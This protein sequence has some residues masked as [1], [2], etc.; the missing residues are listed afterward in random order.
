MNRT[1]TRTLGVLLGSML[2]L[3]LNARATM[4]ADDNFTLSVGTNLSTITDAESAGVGTYLVIQGTPTNNLTVT[5]ITALGFGNGNVLKW[6]GGGQT[7]YRPFNGGSTFT[8]NNLATGET[9]RVSFDIRFAG[10]LASGDN[11]S[12]G[13]VHR[14]VPS[15]SIV[16]A[17][18]DLNSGG[19]Y[20][21]EFRYRTGTYNMS[22]LGAQINSTFTDVATVSGTGYN[23][24]LAVT[25]LTNGFRLAYSRDGSLVGTTTG[26]TASAF[27]TAVGNLAMSGIAFRG[28]VGA[29]TY[30]DDLQI[31]RTLDLPTPSISGVTPSQAITYGTS[32]V[33]LTGIVSAAGPVYP[34]DGETVAVTINGVS[35]NATIAGGAGGFSVIYPTPALG[36]AGSP[37]TITYAYAGGT[38][39]GAAAD[40]TSTA[41][42]VDKATP[43]ISDV[44]ASQTITSG[45]VSVTLTGVVSAAGPVYPADGE[46]VAVT[47]NGV[48]SNATIAGGAGAFSVVYPTA[49]IDDSG[50]PYTITYAYA[51]DANLN[52]AADDTSTS[53]TVQPSGPEPAGSTNTVIVIS[54]GQIRF[55]FTITSGAVYRVQASTNLLDG[56]GWSSLTDPLTNDAGA[57]T[58]YLD[59]NS[60]ALPARS[61]RITS[62]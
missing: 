44:T 46:T 17:N 13:F 47:I 52:A 32:S 30:L 11:F 57:G 54:G 49:S 45:A 26:L 3:N 59:T 34:A 21:S 61:Y 4:L 37:Y 19:G 5:N 31:E 16:Y 56:S 10:S 1:T 43:S 8:L 22:D 9:L 42:T 28:I 29:A 20:F 53:L 33:T 40:D 48:S 2:A 39:V 24:E 38:N 25:R 60:S 36:V 50:S 15:N 27:V 58:F 6:E 14:D 7:Y 35:S 18:L 51:G 55:D 23:M 62:P 12:F 41:L